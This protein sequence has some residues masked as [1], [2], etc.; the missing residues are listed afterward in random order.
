MTTRPFLLFLLG[1][2]V[3]LSA[4]AAAPDVK[5]PP[6]TQE[7]KVNVAPAA[8]ASADVSLTLGPRHA[9]VT[10][11]RKGCNHTGGGNIDVQQPAPDTIV[12]TLGGVAVATPAPACP[13][14][15]ALDFDL[16]Q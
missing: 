9:H 11:V 16:E 5:V 14:H 13:S 7:I 2:G 15:A 12:I 1:L 10:P 6:G 8:P 3:P 4:L